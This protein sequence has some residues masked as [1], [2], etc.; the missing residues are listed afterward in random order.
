M[1]KISLIDYLSDKTQKEAAM[2]F[3]VRQSA[4]SQ[5]LKSGRNIFV[6]FDDSGNFVRCRE[7]KILFEATG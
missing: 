6:E 1:Q 4:V 2:K 7:E 5:M 3:G